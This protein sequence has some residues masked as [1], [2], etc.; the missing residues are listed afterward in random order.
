MKD[1][2]VHSRLFTCY[3]NKKCSYYLA[4]I[5][6]IQIVL[7]NLVLMF[8]ITS[9]FRFLNTVVKSLHSGVNEVNLK[10]IKLKNLIEEMI[11]NLN[12]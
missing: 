12:D 9:D 1:L 7:N 4:D 3:C 10:N 2:E 8:L 11:G 6:S 5:Y